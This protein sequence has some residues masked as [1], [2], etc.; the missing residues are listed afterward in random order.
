MLKA[1][2]VIATWSS[3]KTKNLGIWHA[4]KYSPQQSDTAGKHGTARPQLHRHYTTLHL[5]CFAYLLSPWPTNPLKASPLAAWKDIHC[6]QSARDRLTATS[7]SRHRWC[8]VQ[9]LV[10]TLNIFTRVPLP[11][12]WTNRSS[13]PS[14]GVMK[15]KPLVELNHLT[16]PV[17][18]CPSAIATVQSDRTNLMF[19]DGAL[20]VWS[21]TL[22]GFNR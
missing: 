4:P 8:Q 10:A 21:E 5:G 14:S 20:G 13:P 16:V 12:W 1:G 19:R 15:P 22:R 17:A 6:M 11:T 7:V 9:G 3:Q 18:F 2:C